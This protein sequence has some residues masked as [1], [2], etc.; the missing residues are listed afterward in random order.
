M[1][2][3]A[4]CFI[5]CIPLFIYLFFCVVYLRIRVTESIFDVELP[6]V[7]D[8]SKILSYVEGSGFYRGI[9]AWG[10]F[11]LLMVVCILQVLSSLS[12]L[13]SQ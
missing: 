10:S 11:P 9:D 5:T 6:C 1:C 12:N 2:V 7:S 3:A 4:G 13:F 8:Q